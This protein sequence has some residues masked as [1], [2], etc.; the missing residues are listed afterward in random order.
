M[1]HNPQNERENSPAY[2]AGNLDK[3]NHLVRFFDNLRS[4][5]VILSAFQSQKYFWILNHHGMD[6]LF[7]D[8]VVNKS[9]LALF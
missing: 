8:P 1:G 7:F 3:E 2:M 6:I 9:L 4:L 5:G